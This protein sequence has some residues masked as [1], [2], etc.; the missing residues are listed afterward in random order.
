MTQQ[1]RNRLDGKKMNK[2]LSMNDR[3]LNGYIKKVI[4]VQ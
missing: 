3:G 2:C 1:E 4:L